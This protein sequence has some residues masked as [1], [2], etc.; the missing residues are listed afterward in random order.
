[1]GITYKDSGVDV[2]GGNKF[3]KRIR[4]LVKDTFT[5]E[6]LT[7]IG[8]FAALFDASF[9]Q[10]KHPVLVSGTDGVGTKLKIAQMMN[11][12]NTIGI[13]AV[14]ICVNDIIVTGANG[15]VNIHHLGNF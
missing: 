2:E 11:I 3:V 1:M 14:A 5:K 6:V 15:I 13:D 4:S 8:G 7:D 12:H 10:Y 9:K